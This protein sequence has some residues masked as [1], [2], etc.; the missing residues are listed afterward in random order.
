[1]GSGPHSLLP[2]LRPASP[3]S[4]HFHPRSCSLRSST[5]LTCS[6]CPK[7]HRFSLRDTTSPPALSKLHQP[8]LPK[9][10]ASF[11]HPSVIFKLLLLYLQV[12]HVPLLNFRPVGYATVP[13]LDLNY[14]LPSPSPTFTSGP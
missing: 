7:R 9:E 12:E 1:M 5:S 3:L 10:R 8:Q 13:F 2:L 11:L 4:L 6:S 14:H